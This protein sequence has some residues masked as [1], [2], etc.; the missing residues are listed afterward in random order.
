MAILTPTLSTCKTQMTSRDQKAAGAG[1][2]PCASSGLPTLSDKAFAI[3]DHLGQAYQEGHVRGDRA[4]LCA[5]WNA[6]ALSAYA[7]AQRKLPFNVRKR[8][9]DF[10][11]CANVN[12]GHGHEGQ[13]RAGVPGSGATRR[14]A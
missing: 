3:A 9:G 12:S 4:V 14:G 2:R 11:P 8:S 7:L 1:A 6:M 5:D 13:Q 10:N